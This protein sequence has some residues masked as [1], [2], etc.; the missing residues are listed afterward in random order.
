[1]RYLAVNKY[2]VVALRDLK[3]WV[4]PDIAPQRHQEIIEDRK[5]S[6]E[7]KLDRDNTR[8]PD[9]SSQL[10][11][12][13]DNML[14]HQFDVNEMSKAT[15]MTVSAIEA[16]MKSRK[17]A[18]DD[19]PLLK[20]GAFTLL[21]YPG[22]RH[23]RI[24]FLDGAIR[25]QRETKFS[26]FLPWDDTSYVVADIPEA[27]WW[28]PGSGRELLYLAHTHVP[29]IW[30][31]SKPQLER[32]EWTQL[33]NGSLV[34][35]RK[36][37]NGVS[38]GATVFPPQNMNDGVRM[39]LWLTNGTG[40]SISGLNVQN[41]IMLKAAKVFN[42]RTNENKVYQKPFAACPNATS[43][44]WVITA[45]EQC[46]RPWGSAHCPCLHSD[47]KF[48]DCMPGETQR[49]RGWLSFYEGNDVRQEFSRLKKIGWL[50]GND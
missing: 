18:L 42:Q 7:L 33:E 4:N 49:L 35:A 41:C 26:V 3:K 1:M 39:E 29:T 32:Q 23:P 34:A 9:G 11:Y 6:I 15:G 10:D 48:D 38:F 16:A 25:P 2:Q 8:R 21:P 12:W 28:N 44:K 13:L 36:L 43:D 46:N 47:P 19:R 27:I 14:T 45:W 24:G 17:L 37:P 20:D 30:D 40:N 31:R 5:R 22:G 50:R